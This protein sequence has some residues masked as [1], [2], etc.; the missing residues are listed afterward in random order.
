MLIKDEKGNHTKEGQFF[1]DYPVPV[2]NE[3]NSKIIETNNIVS[4]VF[5]VEENEIHYLH[6]VRYS[7]KYI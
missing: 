4:F 1:V 6:H 2:L 5:K 7:L 3:T